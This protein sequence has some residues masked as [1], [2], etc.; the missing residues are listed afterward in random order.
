MKDKINKWL[1]NEATPNELGEDVKHYIHYI[2][3]HFSKTDILNMKCI[4]ETDYSFG[5]EIKNKGYVERFSIIK[6]IDLD[7]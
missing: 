3:E 7:D 4:R 1:N 6:F 5:I 2:N